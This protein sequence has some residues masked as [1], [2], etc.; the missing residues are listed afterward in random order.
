MESSITNTKT[1]NLEQKLEKVLENFQHEVSN[2]VSKLEI[3]DD[4]C[5]KELENCMMSFVPIFS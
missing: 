3:S 1:F 2:L 5:K 4:E